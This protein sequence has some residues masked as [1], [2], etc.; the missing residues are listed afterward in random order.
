MS[1]TA[2]VMPWLLAAFPES[3]NAWQ[4]YQQSDRYVP[5]EPY[6]DVSWMARQLIE[7]MEAS[8]TGGFHR[9]FLAIEALLENGSDDV[10]ELLTTGFLE[11][12]Q[13]SSLNASIPLEAWERWLSPLTHAAWRAVAGL[14][15]GESTAD[16]FNGYLRGAASRL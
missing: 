9:L 12:L 1:G 8:K 11:D 7:R 15:S 16:E 3:A 4:R 5:G 14:W 6:N 10:R 2:E 13:N